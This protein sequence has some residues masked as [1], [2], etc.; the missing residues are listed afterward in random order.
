[1]RK[2]LGGRG[3]CYDIRGARRDVKRR[4]KKGFLADDDEEGGGGVNVIQLS[5]VNPITFDPWML[6]SDLNPAVPGISI[7]RLRNNGDVVLR[8][9]R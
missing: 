9:P 7:R 3:I 8:S 2:S 5:I 1:M 4:G 6:H